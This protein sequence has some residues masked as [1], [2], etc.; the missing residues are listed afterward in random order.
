[1]KR[2]SPKATAKATRTILRVDM[3]LAIKTPKIS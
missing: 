1:M 3:A 2:E